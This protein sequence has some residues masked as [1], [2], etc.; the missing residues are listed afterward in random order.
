MCQTRKDL[1]IILKHTWLKFLAITEYD[2][3]KQ[4]R[5]RQIELSYQETN[6]NIANCFT[7]Y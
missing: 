3:T 5:L 7:F 6:S 4:L 2:Y 1:P